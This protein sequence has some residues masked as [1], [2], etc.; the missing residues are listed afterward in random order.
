M[1]GHCGTIRRT[2]AGPTGR[3]MKHT[4]ET[5]W[6][7]V[8]R[9]APNVCWPYT[10]PKTAL[11]YGAITY[12]KK[13]WRAHRL[14]WTLTHGPIPI[15]KVVCHKC[16]N[17]PCCNP[18]CLFLG[19]NGDNTRDAQRK[20]RLASGERH[21]SKIH[22]TG[23][24]PHGD[25]HPLR[26]DPELAARGEENGGAIISEPTAIAILARRQ[27]TGQS[28]R[29]IAR[30]FGCSAA[31]VKRLLRGETWVHLPR[32]WGNGEP[33]RAPRARPAPGLKRSRRRLI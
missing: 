15:G 32:P 27:A 4:A 28:S 11:G 2:G 8:Q 1:A 18:E 3:V 29:I 21:P 24:L 31:I 33:P 9:G 23:Y 17:P 26:K 19:S 25:D 7:L 12:R 30:E 22:G 5:F 16:D 13:S 6:A 14:A 20:G 10:G